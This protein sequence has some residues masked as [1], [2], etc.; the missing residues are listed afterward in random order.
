MLRGEER[1][2]QSHKNNPKMLNTVY[3]IVII[4][5]IIHC[6]LAHALIHTTH[7][8]TNKPLCL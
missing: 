5:F 7:S 2:F 6:L 1:R 8:T 4:V 3:L